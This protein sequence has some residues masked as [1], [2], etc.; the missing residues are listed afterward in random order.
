MIKRLT[1]HPLFNPAIEKEQVIEKINEIIDLMNFIVNFNQVHSSCKSLIPVISG[2]M[3][4][5]MERIVEMNYSDD[6]ELL[7]HLNGK[8]NADPGPDQ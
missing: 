3:K 4:K 1:S 2:E 6:P 5:C 8:G 7:P